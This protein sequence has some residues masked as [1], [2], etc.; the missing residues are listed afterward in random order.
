LDKDELSY[1]LER[2]ASDEHG[3]PP[4]PTSVTTLLG[5]FFSGRG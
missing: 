3:P 2:A 5:D 4:P 1:V